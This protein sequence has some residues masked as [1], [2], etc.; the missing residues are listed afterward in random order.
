M[1][2][3]DIETIADWAVCIQQPYFIS[4]SGR[5]QVDAGRRTC[6][7][8]APVLLPNAPAADR[9][10]WLPPSSPSPSTAAAL[11]EH[12]TAP[13]S[14]RPVAPA[15]GHRPPVVRHHPAGG[16]PAPPD[17]PPPPPGRRHPRPLPLWPVAMG[18]GEP[19]PPP[20]TRIMKAAASR[21]HPAA[22]D[23]AGGRSAHLP[24]SLAAPSPCN[25][26]GTIYAI[27]SDFGDR[28]TTQSMGLI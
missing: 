13:P 3:G 25:E 5:R 8:D 26:H 16:A 14:R 1:R 27:S 20:A 9:L 21:H 11:T 15:A 10:L 19:P 2:I 24:P 28:M 22:G 6:V 7:A 17:N 18:A 23:L 12:A 4:S